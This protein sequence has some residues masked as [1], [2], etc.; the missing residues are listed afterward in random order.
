MQQDVELVTIVLTVLQD[1]LTVLVLRNE[2]N[3]LKFL[4]DIMATVDV[5]CIFGSRK[6]GSEEVACFLSPDWIF[7]FSLCSKVLGQNYYA[8]LWSPVDVPFSMVILCVELF[9]SESLYLMLAGL[10][11]VV[12]MESL[13]FWVPPIF[14][15]K[16]KKLILIVAF[17]IDE[18]YEKIMNV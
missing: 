9:S 12:V 11:N 2:W 1:Q 14:W 18:I 16:I 3:W 15:W 5:P 13:L 4:F 6:T 10:I 7:Y 8:T 17:Y